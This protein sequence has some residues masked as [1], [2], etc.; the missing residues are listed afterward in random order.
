MEVLFGRKV[1]DLTELK[2]L[3]AKAREDGLVGTAV[4][5][6]KEIT[7]TDAEFKQF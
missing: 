3:T 7:L 5:V 6:T 2:E 4:E 1:S